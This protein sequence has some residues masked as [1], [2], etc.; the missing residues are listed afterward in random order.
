V[1][2][3]TSAAWWALYRAVQQGEHDLSHAQQAKVNDVLVKL[4]TALKS[5]DV[6]EIITDKNR[7]HP[8]ADWLKFVKTHVARAH[9]KSSMKKKSISSWLRGM[10]PT[11]K[12]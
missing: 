2:D 11:K 6:V 9:I 3:P 10:L 4:D 7:K 8:N 12:N 1:S 5:G